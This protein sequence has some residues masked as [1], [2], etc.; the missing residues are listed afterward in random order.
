MGKPNL[1]LRLSKEGRGK[2][3]SPEMTVKKRYLSERIQKWRMREREKT[4]EL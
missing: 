1:I 4:P 3:G 2:G